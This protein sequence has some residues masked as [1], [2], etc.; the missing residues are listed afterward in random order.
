MLFT[1]LVSYTF[2]EVNK[3]QSCKYAWILTWHIYM[4]KVVLLRNVKDVKDVAD[5][6]FS[7]LI[8]VRNVREINST[9]LKHQN[10]PIKRVL[11]MAVRFFYVIYIKIPM[12]SKEKWVS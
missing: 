12:N 6:E 4:V 3:F 8:F 10:H 7:W 2:Y 9:L 5:V 1:A 11:L